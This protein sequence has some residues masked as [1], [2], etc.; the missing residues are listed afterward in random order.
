MELGFRV[1]QDGTTNDATAASG[2]S[3]PRKG[4]RRVVPLSPQRR[5]APAG[6]LDIAQRD[7]SSELSRLLGPSSNLPVL[8]ADHVVFRNIA[9]PPQLGFPGGIVDR[10]LSPLFGCRLHRLVRGRFTPLLNGIDYS[11]RLF[12]DVD[13]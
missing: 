8:K 10:R 2:T 7:N 9:P 3:R 6:Q 13:V 5:S 1:H 4:G 11:L 12:A